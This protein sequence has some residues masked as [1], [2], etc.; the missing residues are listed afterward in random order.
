MQNSGGDR[1]SRITIRVQVKSGAEWRRWVTHDRATVEG[2][3]RREKG[4]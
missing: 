4:V 3:Q 1:K 2:E